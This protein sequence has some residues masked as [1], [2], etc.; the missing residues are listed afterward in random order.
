M[1]SFLSTLCYFIIVLTIIVFVHEFGHFFVARKCGVKIEEFAIGMGKKLFGYKDKN[2]V[3]WKF[4]LFPVGGYVR[5]YGDDNASSF[6]GYSEN[7]TA[8]ELKYSLIYKHPLKKILVAFAGP[9]M[10]F[11]LAF[12]L[13]LFL[14][15]AHGKPTAKPIIGE[16]SKSS[17]AEKAGI[18]P[19]DTIL[20]ING[21]KIET[22]N[23][24][25]KNLQLAKNTNGKDSQNNV[26][27]EIIRQLKTTN[28]LQKPQTMQLNFKF[29]QNE[30]FGITGKTLQYQKI[31]FFSAISESCATICNITAGT[32]KALWNIIVHQHGM[33]NIGG[34]IAIARESA[35]AGHNGFWAFLYFIALISVSLGAINL[36]PIPMLDGGHVFI[37]FV[38]LVSRRKFS[39]FAYKIFVIIG[40]AF[41]AFL[42]GLGFIN[43]IFINR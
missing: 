28:K 18:L 33:K 7:P 32:A 42:M 12:I 3:L 23:D 20:S 14:F 24:I 8:D 43:D 19:N 26:S 5:M 2:G 21:T 1:L 9:F 4:C 16:I 27:M 34:P 40:I 35:K 29:N 25:R 39:N 15:S 41:I 30:P 22:F 6:G 10:N 13:F 36:I 37:N 17:Q 31:S 11:V 38:E